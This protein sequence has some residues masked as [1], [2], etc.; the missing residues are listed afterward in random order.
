MRPLL[1]AST[2]FVLAAGAAQAQTITPGSGSLTDASGNAWLITQGGSVQENGQWTPGGG[3]TA[4]LTIINGTVYGEDATGRGWFTLSGQYWTSS[5]APAGS[6]TPSAATV[7]PAATTP[8]T[9]TPAA[10]TTA[11]ATLPVTTCAPTAGGAASGGFTTANGQIIA[12]DGSV[13]IAKGVNLYDAAIGDASKVLADFPGINFIRLAAFSYSDNASYLSG[14]I[15]QMSAAR[16]VVE[17]EHHVG[18]GGGVPALTGSDL[19]AENA[20]FQALAGA[21]KGN[22]YVWFGTINEP[23]PADGNLGAEQASNYQTIRGAGAANIILFSAPTP[24]YS[25]GMTNV[26]IDQHEYGWTS[27]YSTNQATVTADLM[28]RVQAD[29]QAAGGI[30]LIIGETGNSTDG[31]NI[32]ANWQQVLS[33]DMSSG[34]GNAYWNWYSEAPADNL[35]DGNGNVSNPYGTTVAG[36][37]ALVANAPASVWAANCTQAAGSSSSA[38]TVASSAAVL[39][40]AAAPGTTQPASA[41]APTSTSPAVSAQQQ[42]VASD[43]ANAQAQLSAATAQAQQTTAAA[44][45]QA[46]AA[47]AQI[48]LL[49]SNMGQA[50][51]Q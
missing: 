36:W 42:Q 13:Y 32:D 29:Q 44:Y 12:P 31:Q 16:V 6:T 47:Q 5:A 24:G 28:Q 26:A 10:T 40:S 8:T 51:L 22:P 15:S 41:S 45:A 43:L 20:W 21:F 39:G 19:S 23:N 35:T 50:P 14:F 30:P 48:N 25:S 4:A 38:I 2:A 27:G 49:L 34:Y 37:I 18:A 7:I 1:L 17:I 46:A 33:A 11:T 3:G 9:T